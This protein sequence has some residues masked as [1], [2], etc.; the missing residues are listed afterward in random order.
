MSVKYV[1]TNLIAKNWK[2]LAD[3]YEK[4]FDCRPIP[5]ERDLS[6]TW[7]DR[8]TGISNTHITGTHLR[9]PGYGEEGPTMEL[10][11]YDSG[12]DTSPARPNTPGFSHIAFSVENVAETAT[13][14]FENGGSAVGELTSVD[15]PGKG[16]LTF[17]YVAD[18][19]GNI[20]EIMKWEK[21]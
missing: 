14:V 1:H 9:L 7:L 15:I 4:V 20:V 12:P 16:G 11:Q 8:A 3:F 10:F 2:Q 19:E 13:A 6:G 18:P 17:Q 21:S 5:P